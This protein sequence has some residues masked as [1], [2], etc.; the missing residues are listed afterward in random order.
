MTE[1]KLQ[2]ATANSRKAKTWANKKV[3]WERLASRC[4]EVVRTSETQGEYAAISK[5]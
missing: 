1:R 3:S 5:D 4:S 2:I